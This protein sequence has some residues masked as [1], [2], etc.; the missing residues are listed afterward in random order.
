[1][2]KSMYNTKGPLKP[3]EN[4][5]N[6]HIITDGVMPVLIKKLNGSYKK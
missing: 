4:R 5:I 6:N 1:M 3:H 2:L